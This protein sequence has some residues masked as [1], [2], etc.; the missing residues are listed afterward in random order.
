M[1]LFDYHETNLPKSWADMSLE[2]K[3]FFVYFLSVG[4]MPLLSWRISVT[5]ELFS[6]PA[7]LFAFTVLSIR[8]RRACSWRWPGVDAKEVLGAGL[9]A[10]LIGYFLY[11]ES[12]L[13]PLTIQFFFPSIWPEP[14]FSYS[15]FFR[16]SI[17]S[18][19]LKPTSWRAAREAQDRTVWRVREARWRKCFGKRWSGR[20]SL[21]PSCLSGS[22]ESHTVF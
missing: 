3:L 13:F 20:S 10:V 6:A 19:F 2:Y 22:T 8:R 12:R 16:T 9:T 5:L 21:L 14:D 7:L 18:P 17:L 15:S 11:A 4:V 1:S